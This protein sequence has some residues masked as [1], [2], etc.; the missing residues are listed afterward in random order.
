MTY[1]N[2]RISEGESTFSDVSQ[3]VTV[4]YVKQLD[5]QMKKYTNGTGYA[6]MNAGYNWQFRH[7]HMRFCVIC[8]KRL[9]Y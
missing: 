4:Y 3:G 1:N 5:G 7:R 8:E 2:F 6:V 9:R